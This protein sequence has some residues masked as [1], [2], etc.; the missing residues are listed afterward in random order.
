MLRLPSITFPSLPVPSFPFPSL[1]LS[2]LPHLTLWIS[3][4]R[5]TGFQF[6]SVELGFCISIVSGISDSLGCIPDSK[7]Q[8]LRFK[9]KFSQILDPKSKTFLDSGIR[10]PLHQATSSLFPA[11]RSCGV[12]PEIRERETITKKEELRER[13]SSHPLPHPLAF[14]P[15]HTLWFCLKSKRQ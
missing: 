15:A 13:E 8:D 4:S 2:S 7:A 5:M 3:D 10:I 1:L 6:L 9:S 11:F 12:W 14:F